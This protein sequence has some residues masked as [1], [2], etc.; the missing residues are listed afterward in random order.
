LRNV[1]ILF[2]FCLIFSLTLSGFAQRM[3][4]NSD[5]IIERFSMNRSIYF[6]Y[7]L[8]PFF[9]ND[10]DSAQIVFTISL[11][12]DLLQF[13]KKSATLYTAKFELTTSIFSSNDSL[14]H[15]RTFRKELSTDAFKKTNS[16]AIAHNYIHSFQLGFGNYKFRLELTDLDTKKSLK[17]DKEFEIKK[18]THPIELL[19]PIILKPNQ[20]QY[21][22]E[23]L[24]VKGINFLSDFINSSKSIVSAFKI[25]ELNHYRLTEPVTIYEQIYHQTEDDSISLVY[26][27]INKKNEIVWKKN[28]NLYSLGKKKLIHK[29]ELDPNQFSHGFYI[30]QITAKSNGYQQKQ[31]VRLYFQ[32]KIKPDVTKSI[33]LDEFGPL[34]YIIDKRE[35]EQL[36]SL[37]SKERDEKIEQFWVERNPDQ[38]NEEN[39]LRDEFIRRIEFANQNFISLVKNNKGWQTDQGKI[40]IIYGPPDDISHPQSP[41]EEYQHEIWIYGKMKQTRR[42]IFVFKPEEGEYKLLR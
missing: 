19:D 21:G 24:D 11:V 6:N 34:Q 3:D 38:D 15:I 42:F 10:P 5:R 37:E 33:E 8:F 16:P 39:Q 35:F 20:K 18:N 26:N 17:R 30:L 1:K 36:N 14:I 22:Y 41:N 25:N 31:Q 29:M 9:L 23:P 4:R 27:I 12:N 13:V 28:D 40:Y 2:S 32:H 7:D